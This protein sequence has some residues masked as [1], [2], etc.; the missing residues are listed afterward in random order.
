MKFIRFIFFVL[1][2]AAAT[3]TFALELSSMNCQTAKSAHHKVVV[4]FLHPVDPLNP[5]IGF[6]LFSA[7]LA[8][9]KNEV[10]VYENKNLRMTPEIYT[11]DINLRGDAEGVY[12]R[13]Y[14]QI[15]SEGEF[16]H[17]TGQV[18]INDLDARA[19][20][21]FKDIGDQPG[22]DCQSRP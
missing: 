5:F 11:T 1:T 9:Y 4:S 7:T 10:K 16:T 6:L 2:L 8:V 14:P 13:L 17:Y 22:L 18:F 20:F 3:R 21:N 12:L 19:Y 15:S